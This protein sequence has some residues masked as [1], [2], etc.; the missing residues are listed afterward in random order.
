MTVRESRRHGLVISTD[1]SR[2]DPD[3]IHAYL[4]RSYW[5]P[6]IPREIVVRALAGSLCFGLYDGDAQIG[7]ARVVTDGAT[8]AYLCDVYVLESHRA[9][10]LGK[11]LMDEVMAHPDLQGLRRFAL[12]TRDAHTL[13]HRYGFAPLSNPANHLEIRAPDIYRRGEPRAGEHA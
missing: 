12:A 3:A 4:M 9:R 13:Y 11:W 5:S 10:G 1:P 7:L 2:L 8:Y 6:G